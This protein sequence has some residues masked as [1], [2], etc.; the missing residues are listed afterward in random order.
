MT[1]ACDSDVLTRARPQ[2]RPCPVARWPAHRFRIGSRRGRRRRD[3]PCRRQPT[4]TLR[5]G[6][7]Q[8]WADTPAERNP[9]RH[10]PAA[11]QGAVTFGE[12]EI[13]TEFVPVMMRTPEQQAAF[14]GEEAEFT[15]RHP[16]CRAMRW[17]VAG[18]GEAGGDGGRS[19]RSN[20]CD[21]QCS[22][23]AWAKPAARRATSTAGRAGHPARWSS[24]RPHACISA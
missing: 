17:S 2:R 10:P 24:T 21:F 7:P 4:I 8:P 3:T 23:P 14:D 20:S 12:I 22:D 16:D 6:W 5:F 11:L 19:P 15:T 13:E 9:L 1:D 18:G